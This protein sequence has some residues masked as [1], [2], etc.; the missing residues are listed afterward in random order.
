MF[1]SDTR[2]QSLQFR[3]RHYKWVQKSVAPAPPMGIPRRVDESLIDLR[4]NHSK[5]DDDATNGCERGCPSNTDGTCNT[6]SDASTCTTWTCAAD[7]LNADDVAA[8]VCEVG[9]PSVV[10]WTCDACSHASTCSTVTC[11]ANHFQSDSDAANEHKR[12]C[13]GATMRLTE[14]TWLELSCFF[15]KGC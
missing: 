9:C 13:P 14:K 12:G 2:H 3:Q 10:D 5:S 15:F 8:K 11:D 7:Y 4:A 6:Y 1:H